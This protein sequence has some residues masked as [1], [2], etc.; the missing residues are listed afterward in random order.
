MGFEKGQKMENTIGSRLRFF[1]ISLIPNLTLILIHALTRCPEDLMGLLAIGGNLITLILLL[2]L[3][4]RTERKRVQRHG[5]EK[6]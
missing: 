3:S 5:L 4:S 1:L 2:A 6:P